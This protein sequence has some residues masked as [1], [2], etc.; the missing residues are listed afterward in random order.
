MERDE[1]ESERERG[2]RDPLPSPL[3]SLRSL[4]A[5][6]RA[7]EREAGGRR[8]EERRYVN[9]KR[10]GQEQGRRENIRKR[11]RE[12]DQEAERGGGRWRAQEG[13]EGGRR[14]GREAEKERWR[15]ACACACACARRHACSS[16]TDGSL[17]IGAVS[18]EYLDGSTNAI[19]ETES[20]TSMRTGV[21]MPVD[22]TNKRE[23][24][25]EPCQHLHESAVEKLKKRAK[26]QRKER[27]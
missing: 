17:G 1:G 13:T 12:R 11:E 25:K 9:G 26:C 8:E 14:R 21:V 10:G 4:C 2:E 22:E 7:C 23:T 5:R 16:V 27:E 3:T 24:K 19:V 6:V 18:A 15:D 20:A